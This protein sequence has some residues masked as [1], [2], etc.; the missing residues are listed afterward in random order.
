MIELF[1][2]L[3][4]NGVLGRLFADISFPGYNSIE[5]FPEK[6]VSAGF[7]VSMIPV[8]ENGVD[9]AFGDFEIHE[10]QGIN[11]IRILHIKGYS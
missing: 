1:S 3:F 6:L 7:I 11:N 8:P 2:N 9:L 5:E 10:L 4:R